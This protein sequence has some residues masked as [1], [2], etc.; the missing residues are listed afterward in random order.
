MI[1]AAAA[2][3]MGM[4][5]AA[6]AA[7][8]AA[9]D[10]EVERPSGLIHDVKIGAQ[11]HDVPYMWSGFHKEPYNVDLN[12]EVMFGLSLAIMGGTLRPALGATINFAGYTSKAYLDARWQLECCWGAFFALGLGVAIHNGSVENYIVDPDNKQLGR[13]VLFHP[14]VEWGYRLSDHNSL[15]LFFEHIS[16]ASTARKNQGLDTLGIRYG[17]RF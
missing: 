2:V 5:W 1:R 6:V 8:A 4:L 15:S 10:A 16:N 14:N 11:L 3:V 12:L 13:R 9:W 7:P 17:Y